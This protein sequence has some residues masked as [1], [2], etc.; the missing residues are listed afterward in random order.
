M[1]TA[2]GWQLPRLIPAYANL[3]PATCLAEKADDT[4]NHAYEPSPNEADF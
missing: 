1:E 2:K 3:G 4:S